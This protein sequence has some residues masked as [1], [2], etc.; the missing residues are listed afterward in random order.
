MNLSVIQNR[1][2]GQVIVV[3]SGI[4]GLATAVRLA[5]EGFGVT[6]V[7]QHSTPG[8]KIRTLPSQAGPIDAG[9]TVLT[10]RPVF[11]ELFK[12]IG[13]RL[14]NHLKLIPVV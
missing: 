12:S 7:E 14:E 3:G 8:G 13:E 9:P 4:A 6:V 1:N 11:E 5:H 10:M 2:K